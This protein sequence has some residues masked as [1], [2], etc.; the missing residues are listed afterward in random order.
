MHASIRHLLFSMVA[1]AALVVV[2]ALQLYGNH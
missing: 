1:L 2:T